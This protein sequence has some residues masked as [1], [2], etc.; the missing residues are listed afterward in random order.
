[1]LTMRGDA[2]TGHVRY[3]ED[4][5]RDDQGRWTSGGG[6]GP[7]GSGGDGG[8]KL[9]AFKEKVRDIISG[10]GRDAIHAVGEKLK[11]NQKE[12]LASA[13]T[14]GLYHVAGL[15]F[16]ADIEAAVHSEVANF[17]TSAEVSVLMARD[18]MRRAVDSLIA[19]R[20]KK[21][22][23]ADEDEI[24]AA[25]LKLK[26]VLDK[27]D[28]KSGVR[29]MPIKPGKDESQDAWM[30]RCMHDMSQ[31]D[32]GRTNE[33]NV[34][35]CLSMWRD[36]DK[37][38]GDDE[39]DVDPDDVPQP[40]DNEDEDDFMDRC[41]S[42]IQE[43]Y[44]L[45]DKAIT[46][47]CQNRWDEYGGNGGGGGD[48]D[49][50]YRSA[51][52]VVHK[53]HA[54]DVHGMEFIL[55]DESPDRIGDVI[56][57]E[58]WELTQFR[59]NPVA[60]FNH[61]ADW[62]IGRWSNLRVEDKSLKG[63]LA[64]A[65]EGTS[66]RID[67][68]RKLVEHGILRA[69]SV[70]FRELD[71]E[72]LDKKNPFGGI[73]FKKQELMECSLVS[74]PANPNALAVVKSL[75]I[76]PQTLDFVFAKKG[77]RRRAGRRAGLI[78]K[79]AKLNLKHGKGIPMSGLAQ[80][81]VDLQEG[82]NASKT[83]L[84]A[85]LEHI[86]DSNVSDAD[87]EKTS[88]LNAD[89]QQKEKQYTAL[90][91]SEKLLGESLRGGDGKISTHKALVTTTAFA[92]ATTSKIDVGEQIPKVNINTKKSKDADPLD[93][94]ARCATIL[95]TQKNL[96]GI[97]S[98]DEARQRV[99]VAMGL[100]ED[101]EPT[102][103]VADLVIKAQS[104]PAMTTVAGWAQELVHI[105][106]T[107]LMPLLLPHAI[108]TQLAAKGLALSFGRAGKIVIPT[109]SRTPAL[110]GS[111]VGE[112]QAIPVRQG[113]FSSQTLVPKK[114]AVISSWTKEMDTY[115]IPAIEGIIREAIQVDTGIAIDSVLIDANPVTV[116]RPAGLLNGVVV[117]APT[118]GG[119]LTSMLGDVK[120]LIGVLAANTYG[121]IRTPVW[122]LNPQE[123]L[124]ASLA[125]T[126]NGV[127]PFREEV[128]RGTLNNIPFIE[129]ATQAPGQVILMD[130]ADF[131]TVGA[132]G[133]RLDVSDSATLH[134]EDTTPLDLV[135]GGSPP[136]VAAPQRSLFQTDSL[137]L[138]LLMW[139]NWT[140][141]R[142]GTIVYSTP[143]TWS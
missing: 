87:L 26:A 120:K 46:N 12:L 78:G 126:A 79:H 66:P 15:D 13:V 132:E 43:N 124:A 10:P 34:A 116:I 98:V 88:A 91:E 63:T 67:E 101:D 45:D 38:Y 89:I 32:S 131:V 122:I 14:F 130:A 48:D 36:K 85:H 73:K 100:E 77:T 62:P 119:G 106:Y 9:A 113:A 137:A 72:H 49:D 90:V 110:A 107:D 99:C 97:V 50:S 61:R 7:S 127:F 111:F 76:S 117:T 71:A 86:D 92:R 129:S 11:E 40:D 28:A 56:L 68:I 84:A 31:G 142:T 81:I 108:L 104:A 70:G 2:A 25:L 21:A 74:V 54:A 93:Y 37:A 105:I 8:A 103:L 143:V 80:R 123:V 69:V 44:D 1:M 20:K 109:R 16:P 102:K 23:V 5:P 139:L 4:E 27:N 115:S 24:L 57:S 140:Q 35:A 118:A 134:M 59:R 52:G 114:V 138:R 39:G 3:S 112:G 22:A 95:I 135:S 75:Q 51:G 33:Q 65:P 19:L 18:Y 47:I 94:I 133:P 96:G 128:A 136:T 30:K 6:D 29:A 60:L 41:A 55:S 141:R 17:A 83:A 82:I 64:L 125:I 58:G 42:A 53:T 121:N